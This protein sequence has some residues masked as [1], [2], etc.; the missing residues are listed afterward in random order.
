MNSTV[1][2]DITASE[3]S[4][5]DLTESPGVQTNCLYGIGGVTPYT[6]R[7][8]SLNPTESPQI[9]VSKSILFDLILVESW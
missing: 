2:Y 6:M 9:V 5:S 7:A 8:S 1:S 4:A 3:R